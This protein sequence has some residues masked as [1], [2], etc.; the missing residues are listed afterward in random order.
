MCCHFIYD[1]DDVLRYNIGLEFHFLGV[2][3]E[4]PYSQYF[5]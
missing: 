5:N 1:H 4:N 3:K 2:Y